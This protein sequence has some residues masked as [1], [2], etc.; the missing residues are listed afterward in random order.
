MASRAP[1]PI[2]CVAV[3]VVCM[4]PPHLASADVA[5]LIDDYA[6]QPLALHLLGSYDPTSV[7]KQVVNENIGVIGSADAHFEFFSN[8]PNV[9]ANGQ[10]LTYNFNIF[11]PRDVSPNNPTGLSDTWNIVLTGHAPT[12]GDANNVSVDTHFRSDSLDEIPPTPLVNAT[13]ILERYD[14]GPP[15]G[16]PDG[17][18]QY[19]GPLLSD[20]T[21]GFNSS[22][23]EPSS[24]AMLGVGIA[25]LFYRRRRA[26]LRC[27]GL[28]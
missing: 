3:S 13:G 27:K 17:T 20:L 19:V 14:L 16:H 2:V 7:N 8:D 21:T 24:I 23:P 25:G 18:Y 28:K 9:P 6:E 12:P 1:N 5:L 4:F 11:S 26:E 10:T 15:S 22:A